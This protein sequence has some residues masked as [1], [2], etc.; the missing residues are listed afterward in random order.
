MKDVLLYD[1]VRTPFG[2]YGGSL[3]GVRADNLMAAAIRSM[4]TRAPFDLETIEDVIVG[5]ANQAGEDGRNVARF[6]ALMADVPLSAGGITVNRLCG[7]GMAAVLDATRAIR[8]EE[9]EL[10]IAGGVE[11]MSRA[12]FAVLKSETP[13]G[14]NFEVDDTTLGMRFPNPAFVERFGNDSLIQTAETI[15]AEMGL[16]RE[17]GDAFAAASQSRY[18]RARAD[19]FYD[20]EIIPVDI[21]D[22]KKRSLLSIDRDEHPRPDST[23]EVLA[24]LRALSPG[25]VVTAGNASGVNDGAAALFVGNREIGE[26]AGI[27]PRARV[28]AAAVAGVDPG[29]M[30]MGPVPASRKALARAGLTLKDMDVIEINEAFA[31]QVL[32]CLKALDLDPEDTRI[33]ANGGAIA[34]GHPLGASGARLTLTAMRQLCLGAGRY[35]LATM[36]IGVG[37]GIAIILEKA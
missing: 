12:P 13:F 26:K 1:G 25:G 30:G 9:G 18:A 27:A 21:P 17:A 6:A 24:K 31:V 36:C 8:C 2:R 11:S 19:G 3:S 4:T 23:V 28:L 10:F 20:D 29:R 32:A 14:R 33:N 16:T 7:S 5:D 34:I 22:R 15:A 35:A 37:Q